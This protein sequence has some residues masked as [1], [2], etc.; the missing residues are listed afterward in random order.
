MIQP[1]LG[2]ILENGAH[3]G[4]QRRHD[5]PGSISTFSSVNRPWSIAALQIPTSALIEGAIH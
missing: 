1:R 5:E 2:P 4:Q 3:Q